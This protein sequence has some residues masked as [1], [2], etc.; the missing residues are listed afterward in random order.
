MKKILSVIL[1]MFLLISGFSVSSNAKESQ[2][3]TGTISTTAVFRIKSNNEVA[4]EDDLSYFITIQNVETK[5]KYQFTISEKNNNEEYELYA[6]L[7]Q[8]IYE[9]KKI[10]TSSNNFSVSLDESMGTAFQIGNVSHT[11]I[12]INVKCSIALPS[13]VDLLKN[14]ALILFVATG[15]IVG[16]LVIKKKNEKE[17]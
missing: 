10:K 13:F 4:S 1:F 15:A 9:I 17:I 7:T 11:V 3:T 5:E 14:N 16:L 12:P 6:P 8:G 2:T